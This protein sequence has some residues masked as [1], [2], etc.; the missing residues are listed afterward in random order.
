MRAEY[1]KRLNVMTSELKQLVATS[2]QY[3]VSVRNQ[4]TDKKELDCLQQQLADL[5]KLKVS[6]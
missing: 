4:H 3:V 6:F 2:K 5:N 1:E